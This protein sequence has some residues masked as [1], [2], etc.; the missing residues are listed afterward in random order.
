MQAQAVS[1]LGAFKQAGIGLGT[2]RFG[3]P[4]PF[5]SAEKLAI[6]IGALTIRI[7]FWGPFYYNY[8][9]GP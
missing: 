7:G 1:G 2:P 9:K 5:A 8:D 4:L 6:N 3:G